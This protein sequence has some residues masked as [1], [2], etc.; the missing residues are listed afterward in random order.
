MQTKTVIKHTRNFNLLV[1]Q[2]WDWFAWVHRPQHIIFFFTI[3]FGILHAENL[4]TCPYTKHGRGT[5]RGQN[6]L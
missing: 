2:I 1:I 5:G 4:P 3:S 6:R